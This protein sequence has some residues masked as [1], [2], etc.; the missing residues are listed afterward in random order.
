MQT[1]VVRTPSPSWSVAHHLSVFLPNV[2]TQNHMPEF[3]VSVIELLG[4]KLVVIFL[5]F[6]AQLDVL[7][8]HIFLSRRLVCVMVKPC[9]VH[10]SH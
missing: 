2:S 7:C 4:N 6:L 10:A 1:F 5:R 3:S 8:F 9:E